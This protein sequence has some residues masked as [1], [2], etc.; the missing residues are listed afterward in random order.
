V[1]L[2]SA[3]LWSDHCSEAFIN[4][5]LCAR[6]PGNSQQPLAT[7][8]VF[9]LEA[10][11]DCLLSRLEVQPPALKGGKK[12][13]SSSDEMVRHTYEKI[14]TWI[15]GCQTRWA[16]NSMGVKQQKRCQRCLWLPNKECK[17]LRR[18]E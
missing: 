9:A 18:K 12:G 16:I 5:L 3:S 10:A 11:V 6:H 4:H 17:E 7:I 1:L 15:C 13:T 14:K 8:K 2:L